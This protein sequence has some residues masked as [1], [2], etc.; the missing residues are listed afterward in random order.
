MNLQHIFAGVTAVLLD[1]DG[2]LVDSN[3]Q[4]A[5]SWVDVF[6]EHGRTVDLFIVKSLIGLGADN[7]VAKAIGTVS[8]EMSRSM[9]RRRSEIFL[10][11]YLPSVIPIDKSNELVVRL[12]DKGL[13]VILVTAA[14]GEERKALLRR[15]G[16]EKQFAEI[17]SA[18]Q[19]RHSK[20]APDL[21]LACL[22]GHE[23]PPAQCLLVGDTPYDAEAAYQAGM[24]FLGVE[25]GGYNAE[26]LTPAAAVVPS[27]TALYHALA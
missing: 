11:K 17:V 9:E 7:L 15:G 12:K 3:E 16:L 10:E 4:K 18:D 21:L 13:Q 23:F 8:E 24:K 2:T 25:T 5:Q 19:V 22:E 1:L 26:R 20:P 6:A 27:V 14:E